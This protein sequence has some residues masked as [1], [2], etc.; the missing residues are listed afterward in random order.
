MKRY[1]I[2]FITPRLGIGGEELSTFSLAKEFKRCGH[3]VYILSTKG[4]LLSEYIV[5]SI[6]VTMGPVKGRKPWHII[7]GANFIRRFIKKNNI[8]IIHSQ[9]VIPTLMSYLAALTLAGKR[10]QI[11]WHDRGIKHYMLVKMFFSFMVD[12]IITNS[13]Y[14]MNKLIKLGLP[15]E[16]ITFIH[17]CYNL[18]Y[19]ILVDKDP[20]LLTELG[21]RD[22]EFIIGTVGRIVA[23]K[24]YEY[25]LEAAKKVI[26]KIEKVKFVIVGDGPLKSK[27]ENLSSEFGIDENVIF[28][29]FRKDIDRFY[30][31]MDIFI[32]PSIY[33]QLGDVS[34]EAMFY[35]KP[36]IASRVGGIPEVV[37]DGESG[38]LVPSGDSEGIANRILYLLANA[39]VRQ[40]MGAAGRKRVEAYFTPERVGEEV[41]KVYEHLVG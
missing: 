4:P 16:K 15:K 7:K 18:R 20:N 19:P 40:K 23:E 17:D 36:V 12:F 25:L 30:L 39:E 27:L 33:E 35:R 31:I 1:N 14:E 26:Q 9:S 38:F 11:I 21:I 28:T 13:K 2:L 10:P 24:G 8:Q 37:I 34:L 5:N 6:N 41:E 3:N 29:G 32:L 22:N